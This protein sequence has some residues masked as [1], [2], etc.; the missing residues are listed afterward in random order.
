M[1]RGRKKANEEPVNTKIKLKSFAAEKHFD[2]S[3]TEGL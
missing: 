2:E 3:L 1:A